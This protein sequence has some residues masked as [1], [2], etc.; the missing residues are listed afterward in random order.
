MNLLDDTGLGIALKKGY[1]K[2]SGEYL[3]ANGWLYLLTTEPLSF[4][5]KTTVQYQVP[6]GITLSSRYMAMV[7]YND[8]LYLNGMVGGP[9]ILTGSVLPAITLRVRMEKDVDIE[10]GSYAVRLAIAK[11]S[12]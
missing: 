3:V 5:G 8:D 4:K 2:V 7:D 6:H 12:T 1:L 10:P 9:S 11:L